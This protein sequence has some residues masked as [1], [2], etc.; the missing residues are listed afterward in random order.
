LVPRSSVMTGDSL[1]ESTPQC[2]IFYLT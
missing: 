1:N 2:A